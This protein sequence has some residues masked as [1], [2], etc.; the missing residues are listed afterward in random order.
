MKKDKKN[1]LKDDFEKAMLRVSAA[2]HKDVADRLG[3]PHIR[4]VD[5]THRD[6]ENKFKWCEDWIE[7]KFRRRL[8]LYKRKYPGFDIERFIERLTRFEVDSKT[9]RWWPY[10]KDED[11]ARINKLRRRADSLRSL[12]ESSS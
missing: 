11:I 7:E 3:I 5:K 10:I 12:A 2:W 9:Q 4:L 8:Y 1:F 6:E